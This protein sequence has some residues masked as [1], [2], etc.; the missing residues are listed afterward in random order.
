MRM[1]TFAPPALLA[2]IT[3]LTLGGC[4]NDGDSGSADNTAAATQ[5][6]TATGGST[7]GDDPAATSAQ[8]AGIEPSRLPDPHASFDIPGSVTGDDQAVLKT[9]VYGLWRDGQTVTLIASFTPQT[10]STERQN[11]FSW[12]GN[13]SLSASLVDTTNLRRHG[14]LGPIGNRLQTSPTGAQFGDGQTLYFY[15]VFAAPPED[16]TTMNV[17]F[18]GLPA[19]T[20][21][22]VR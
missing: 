12:L 18:D 11:L 6:N 22:P 20:E 19:I 7:A 14:V 16:V 1:R 17:L 9:D 10:S 8:E 15:A 4:S 21:V 5:T 2:L 3:A 13:N